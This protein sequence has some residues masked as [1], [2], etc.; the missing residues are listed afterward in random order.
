MKNDIFICHNCPMTRTMAAIGTKWKPIII[1]AIGIKTL[2]FGEIFARVEIISK[3]VLTQQ[4][5]ELAEDEIVTRT[6]Y[7]EI[8]LRVEYKL[9]EKGIEQLKI[10]NQLTLWNQKYNGEGYKQ[11]E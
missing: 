2:R 9:T 4:L 8:P 1:Y 3:K 10:L 6:E 11:E 5:K 7:N